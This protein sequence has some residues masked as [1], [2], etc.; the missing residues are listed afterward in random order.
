MKFGVYRLSTSGR[1]PVGKPQ[2]FRPARAKGKWIF[3]FRV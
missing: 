3:G 2:S 1:M